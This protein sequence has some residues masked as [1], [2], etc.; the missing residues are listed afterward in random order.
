VTA[1]NATA[2]PQA[3]VLLCVGFDAMAL[4]IARGARGARALSR[5]EFGGRVGAP[6]LLDILDHYSITST[7]FIPGHTAETF[8]EVTRD[9]VSRG[10]EVAN[11]GYL[12]EDFER[13]TFAEIQSVVD[14]GGAAL[15]RVTGVRPKGMR[16]PV[17]DFDGR[18]FAFLAEDGYEYDSSMW[19]G[20][21]TLYWAR[22]LDIVPDDGPV[23]FGSPVDLVEVPLSL[24]MQDF[25]YLEAD[26]G[27][28]GLNGRNTPRQVEE[29]WREQFDYMYEREP[30]GVLNVTIHPQTIGRG[31]RAAMLERFLEHCLSRPGVRFTTCAVAAGEFRAQTG[32]DGA[33]NAF[34][35][36]E[37]GSART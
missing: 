28:M 23:Q 20:E 27:S 11:H 31:S 17:G 26:L 15:E 10:H 33:P 24:M 12:H 18:L 9:V 8:P 4:W 25:V 7:W 5:G 3:T 14:R 16:A 6:R 1:E 22:G 37:D 30:G 2:G 35:R 19:D 29:I 36:V 34:R 13:L 21:Y 32:L